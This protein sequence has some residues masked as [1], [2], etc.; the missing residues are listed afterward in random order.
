MLSFVEVNHIGD[1]L[2]SVWIVLCRQIW[3][4][5]RSCIVFALFRG[6]LSFLVC[7]IVGSLCRSLFLLQSLLFFFFLLQAPLL[8]FIDLFLL[9]RFFRLRLDHGSVLL[10]AL[11]VRTEPVFDSNLHCGVL[12]AA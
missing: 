4:Y 11:K 1:K 8:L 6:S 7:S 12:E 3:V 5:L 10:D 2:M 9:F